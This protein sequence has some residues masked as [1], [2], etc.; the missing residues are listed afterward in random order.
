MSE[1]FFCG[2]A[3]AEA[4]RFTLPTGMSVQ[5]CSTCEGLD[6]PNGIA[7]MEGESTVRHRDSTDV[8]TQRIEQA[9]L[10]LT[11]RFD[12][13]FAA[14]A[15]VAERLANTVAASLA[16]A[17]TSE[18]PTGR[19]AVF[20]DESIS[21]IAMVAATTPAE[22]LAKVHAWVHAGPET[23]PSDHDVAIDPDFRETRGFRPV[24]ITIPPYRLGGDHA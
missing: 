1:C 5:L 11:A 22:A 13:S 8:P 6:G 3:T 4:R 19:Y 10:D 15:D 2:I 21:R 14:I 17:V 7:L 24:T 18:P 23:F 9:L 16:D 12:V 20:L